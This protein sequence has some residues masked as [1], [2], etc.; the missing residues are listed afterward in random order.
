MTSYANLVGWPFTKIN[1][2]P[3]QFT[4]SSPWQCDTFG[5]GLW[6]GQSIS[7]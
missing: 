1:L 3:K 7:Y 6:Q 5:H 2:C 4:Q